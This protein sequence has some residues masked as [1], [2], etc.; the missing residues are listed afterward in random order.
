[1]HELLE[2]ADGEWMSRDDYR[3]DFNRQ[4]WRT[5]PS[6]FWK[7]ERGQNFQ[8][9]GY[10]SWEAFA[11]GDWQESLRLIEAGR[12]DMADYHRRVDD[13]GFAVRRVRVVEEPISGYVQWELH[14]LRMRD[15]FGSP[16]RVVGPEHVA[17]WE[18]TAPLPEMYTL[19]DE[20]MYQNEYD[21]RGVFVSA[22]RF[23]DRDL[24]RR[25]R[26]TIADL[27]VMGEPLQDYFDRCVADLP[28]PKSRLLR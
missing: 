4:F 3:A 15:Q 21:D 6:G 12:A 7:L 26:R 14:V 8:E 1:M 25:C 2:G 16:V 28:E 20:V 18:A 9:P 10:D 19:G 17:P 23:T 27:F 24:I 13:H 11:R 5:G 22:R